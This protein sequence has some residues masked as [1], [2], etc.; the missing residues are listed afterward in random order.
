MMK[1]LV[2]RDHEKEITHDPALGA[3]EVASGEKPPDHRRL[4]KSGE[5]R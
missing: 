1:K 4:E 5:P 2:G 3:V